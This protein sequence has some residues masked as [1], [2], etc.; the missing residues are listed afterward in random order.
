M[1]SNMV[2]P[3]IR[4]M[5]E[6][7]IEVTLIIAS[8]HCIYFTQQVIQSDVDIFCLQEVWEPSVQRKIY[9]EVKGFYPYALSAIDLENEPVS[10]GT[11]ACDSDLLDAALACRERACQGLTGPAL[12]FC[13][14]LR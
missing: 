5:N 13:G 12:A 2:S 6:V 1:I 7:W 4:H 14:T 8:L 9:S 11:T 3:L 10:D